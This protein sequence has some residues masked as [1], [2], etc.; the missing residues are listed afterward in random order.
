MDVAVKNLKIT[1]DEAVKFS[2][3]E[4]VGKIKDKVEEKVTSAS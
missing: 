3:V 4:V 2:N 1:V